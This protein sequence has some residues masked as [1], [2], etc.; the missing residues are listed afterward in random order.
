MK[1]RRLRAIARDGTPASPW[2]DINRLDDGIAWAPLETAGYVAMAV[3]VEGF[4]THLLSNPQFV[5]FWLGHMGV[6]LD[7]LPPEDLVY[8]R[9]VA[10]K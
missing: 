2:S 8:H 1:P 4:Y 9:L 7:E 6:Y 5:T 10:Q 3:E